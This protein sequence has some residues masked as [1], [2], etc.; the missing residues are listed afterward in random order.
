LRERQAVSL[1]IPLAGDMLQSAFVH[2]DDFKYFIISRQSFPSLLRN[3]LNGLII[4]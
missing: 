3:Y 2:R 4:Q 1:F